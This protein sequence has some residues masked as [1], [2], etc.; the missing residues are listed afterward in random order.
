MKY[1][2][3]VEGAEE[4]IGRLALFNMAGRRE[5]RKAVY[6]SSNELLG[7]AKATVPVESG[8]TQR[9]LRTIFRRGGLE[10]TVGS[11]YYV[12]RFVHWGTKNMPGRPF[13]ANA[14]EIERPLY[15]ARLRK[16]LSGAARAVSR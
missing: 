11:G 7:M 6:D 15:V 3:E 1:R 16:A 13:L 8:E 5:V 10:A 4:V 14:W 2:V 9:S 12:A